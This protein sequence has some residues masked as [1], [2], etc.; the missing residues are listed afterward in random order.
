MVQFIPA[1]IMGEAFLHHSRLALC[2]SDELFLSFLGP[3]LRRNGII[4]CAT[5]PYTGTSSQHRHDH[6]GLSLVLLLDF[7]FGPFELFGSV[8]DLHLMK[9]ADHLV[10][11]WPVREV[12]LLVRQIDQKRVRQFEIR[13]RGGEM[14]TQR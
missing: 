6:V 1:F 9:D 2:Q 7:S 4:A 3:N 13:L 10:K 12:F 14:A 11:S 5:K 8:A